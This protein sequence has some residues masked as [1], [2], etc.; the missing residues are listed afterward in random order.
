M[1]QVRLFNHFKLHFS[2]KS[3]EN[4]KPLKL[5][6]NVLRKKDWAIFQCDK[7]KIGTCGVN[8]AS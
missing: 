6:K 8:P 1:W 5:K 3:S 2:V 4:G 7:K